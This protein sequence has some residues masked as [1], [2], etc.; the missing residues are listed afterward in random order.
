MAVFAICSCTSQ[1]ETKESAESLD[2]NDAVVDESVLKT[3]ICER[4]LFLCKYIPDHGIAADA[5]KYMTAEY[6][7]AYSEAI[8]APSNSPDGIGDEEF[9][10]YF[11]SGQDP[12]EPKFHISNPDK[13]VEIIDDTHVLVQNITIDDWD[14]DEIYSSDSKLLLELVDGEWVIADFND[15]KLRCEE[16]VKLVRSQYESGEIIEYMRSEGFEQSDIDVYLSEIE[17]FYQ[18]YGR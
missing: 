15:T 1:N 14:G 13:D 8:D 10:F 12:Q 18:K 3:Q 11:V 16:Y 2:N 9:L 7:R 17:A 5:E 4:A 6:F